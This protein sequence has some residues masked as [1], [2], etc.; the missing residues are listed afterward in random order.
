M[1]PRVLKLNVAISFIALI[2]NLNMFSQNPFA[3][4]IIPEMP[5]RMDTLKMVFYYK[6]P[7]SSCNLD[8]SK[9]IITGKI[10]N[11]YP[12]VS[13]NGT[14]IV[15][16]GKDTIIIGKLSSLNYKLKIHPVFIHDNK[17]IYYEDSAELSESVSWGWKIIPKNPT[18]YDTVKYAFD[19]VASSGS[20]YRDSC[21]IIL[22]NYSIE[23]FAFVELND[24]LAD[25]WGSGKVIIGKLNSG[26][27]KLKFHL[28]EIYGDTIQVH[29]EDSSYFNVFSQIPYFIKILPDNPKENDIIKIVLF[30][31]TPG[32]PCWLNNIEVN[33]EGSVIGINGNVNYD[34]HDMPYYGQDTIS[35]GQLPAGSYTIN[36]LPVFVSPV[37]TIEYEGLFEFEVKSIVSTEIKTIKQD[38]QAYFD[39]NSGLLQIKFDNKGI[40]TISLIDIAGKVLINEKTN[41]YVSEKE[42]NLSGFSKGVYLLHI[43]GKENI[44]VYTCKIIK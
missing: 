42:Y 43:S 12:F 34:L 23:I 37:D 32:S 11:V 18:I 36:M 26:N 38:I 5:T 35:I 10:I 27:Y 39:I 16:Y 22:N 20:A 24:A 7:G 3:Y 17:V 30:Y 41:Y 15:C 13:Y 21:K 19:W 2:T 29:I 25:S 8:S 14:D 9:T 31:N 1:I 44:S 33:N 6:T 40:Y 28:M 4:K